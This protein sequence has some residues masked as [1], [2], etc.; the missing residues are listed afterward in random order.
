MAAPIVVAG[1]AGRVI[2]KKLAK[3]VAT[4]KTPHP[5]DP[6]AAEIDRG[7]DAFRRDAKKITSESD[8]RLATRGGAAVAATGAALGADEARNRKKSG[9][10]KRK[11]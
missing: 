1:L 4:K 7:I 11:K 2:A 6:K 3:K 5:R 10:M 9:Q 8:R